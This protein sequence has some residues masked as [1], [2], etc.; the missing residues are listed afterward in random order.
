VKSE[1]EESSERVVAKLRLENEKSN[2]LIA[3]LEKEMKEGQE[4]NTKFQADTTAVLKQL[5]DQTKSNV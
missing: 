1:L 2:Q 3:K 4:A 5:L